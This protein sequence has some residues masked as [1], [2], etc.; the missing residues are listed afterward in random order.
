M[1]L[2]NV[3]GIYLRYDQFRNLRMLNRKEMFTP[4]FRASLVYVSH[5]TIFLNYFK[6]LILEIA[7]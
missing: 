3:N 2:C 4:I 1:H 6:S 5:I 7:N